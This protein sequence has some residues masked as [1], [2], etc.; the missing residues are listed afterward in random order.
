MIK[1]CDW[2]MISVD[3]NG[4]SGDYLNGFALATMKALLENG[5]QVSYT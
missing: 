5:R 2:D 4:M 3:D 1:S